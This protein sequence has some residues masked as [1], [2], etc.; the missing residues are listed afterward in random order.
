MSFAEGWQRNIEVR[1]PEILMWRSWTESKGQETRHGI[2]FLGLFGTWAAYPDAARSSRLGRPTQAPEML[3][4]IVL[5]ILKADFAC[6]WRL[7]GKD[8]RKPL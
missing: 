8:L 6:G 1:R 5:N 7:S 4:W 2:L 3:F